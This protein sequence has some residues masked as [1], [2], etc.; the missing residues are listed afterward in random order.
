MERL[1]KK[2]ES[3]LHPAIQYHRLRTLIHCFAQWKTHYSQSFKENV[4]I[5]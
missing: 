3:V 2:E 5:L 1:A 4:L